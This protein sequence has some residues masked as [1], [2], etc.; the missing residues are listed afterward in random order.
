[1][2][3]ARE[4]DV[5]VV[6]G[7]I[8]GMYMLYKLRQ[9]GVSTAVFEAGDGVGGTWYWN[10]YPGARVDIESLDYSYSFSPELEQE[11]S[12]SERF[13]TQPELLRYL[14]H[15]ADRF[16]LRSGIQFNTRVNAGVWDDEARQW[17]ISTSTGE[18]LRARYFVMASGCL[19]DAQVPDFPGI[20]SFTGKT[21]HTGNW[22]HEGVD[23]TGQRVGVIGTGSSGIQSIPV[24]AKE[25]K[26]LF[27]FQRTANFSIPARNAPLDPEYEAATKAKYRERREIARLSQAGTVNVRPDKKVQED[28][29]DVR[30]EVFEA[31]WGVGGLGSVTAAY[32]NILLD[33]EA[34]EIAAEYVRS[35]IREIVKDPATAELLC[36][37]EYPIGTK[38]L[39]LDTNYYQTF[40]QDH[41]H[42]VNV[43][44]TPIS[45][46]TPTGVRVG[47]KTYEVDALVFATGFDAMTGPLLA[48]DIRG[49]NGL[50][51]R[52]KWAEGPKA[53]LGIASAGFP[54][55]FMITGPGSPSVLSNMI[56]SIEQHVEWTADLI[57][58][59]TENG[60]DEFDADPQAEADWVAHVNELAHKTLYPKAASWY[61]GANI[62]GKPRV[63]MPY[64]GGVGTYRVLC[65]QIADEGYKGFQLTSAVS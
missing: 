22:P 53:Y 42:L 3:E 28:P 33:D 38:R 40:N 17:E 14:N 13:P 15:V 44:T 19:S 5:V 64:I 16:D 39:C 26:E 51:L 43:R 32:N 48:V 25:A 12:W 4:V 59:L 63:F 30:Q 46:I 34:N 54:N 60:L 47:D 23:F 27:V 56:M 8:A 58:Y 57:G 24:I 62:P 21:Y 29:A 2:S 52:E 1:M 37:R 41:V 55:L 35:K 49:K 18:T 65:Q 50:T 31:R 10:R 45:E 11:W 20:E 36:P 61:M 6:G 9:L 7:G